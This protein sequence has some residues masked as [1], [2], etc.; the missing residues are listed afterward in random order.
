[1]GSNNGPKMGDLGFDYV[2]R[3]VSTAT[4][5]GSMWGLS[6]RALS[7]RELTTVGGSHVALLLQRWH[8][9]RRWRGSRGR[10]TDVVPHVGPSHQRLPEH[11][12]AAEEPSSADGRRDVGQVRPSEMLKSWEV[13]SKTME[14][15][16]KVIG[17]DLKFQG[18]HKLFADSRSL[19]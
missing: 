16:S 5:L 17:C 19:R 12:G 10:A 11:V 3:A 1:M 14:R 2:P 8:R 7:H 13:V 18:K 6:I 4:P 15:L 9:G